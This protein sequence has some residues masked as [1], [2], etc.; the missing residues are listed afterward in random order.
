MIGRAL[1]LH[2]DKKIANII[3]PFS[4]NDEEKEI[5]R[6]LEVLSNNDSVIKRS[7]DNKIN[8]GYIN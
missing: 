3:L 1:R 5:S 2:D 8:G 6:F 7:F 4:L